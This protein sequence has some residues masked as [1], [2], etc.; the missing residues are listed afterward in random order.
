MGYN[1]YLQWLRVVLKPDIIKAFCTLYARQ[2]LCVDSEWTTNNVNIPDKLLEGD[3]HSW[4]R[5]TVWYMRRTTVPE[6]DIYDMYK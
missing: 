3:L 4:E 5:L 2:V 6:T 1:G